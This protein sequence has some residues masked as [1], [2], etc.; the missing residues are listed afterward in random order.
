MSE[1]AA[2]VQLARS[3]GRRSYRRRVPL[4]Y[5]K[6]YKRYN[7]YRGYRSAFRKA[8]A[9]EFPKGS[10]A[11]ISFY[12]QDEN[13]ANPRQKAARK[14]S[15]YRGPGAYFSE[16]PFMA[17]ALRGAGQWLG[18]R[19]MPGAGGT[20][21]REMAGRASKWLGFGAYHT[22][23]SG[24]DLVVDMPGGGSAQQI[25]SVADET[26]DLVI[27]NTEFIGNVVVT[28]STA[29]S[30]P[31]SVQT[32]ALNPGITA[33]F[34]FLSQIAQN[35][36]LYD[37]QQLLFQ[38]KPLSGESGAASNNLGS[39]IM[40]THYDPD[41]A[42]FI[43]KIQMENY[44]YS[45]STKPSC[46]AV[47]GV[48]CKPGSSSTN[49]LYVRA[50]AVSR[51]KIFTDVGTFQLAT[52]G[53]PFASA[54]SQVV[55]ELHVTYTVTLS[56]PQL[57]NSLLG[58]GIMQD[59]FSYTVAQNSAV[60]SSIVASA[61][62]LI[63]GVVSG[64]NSTQLYTFPTSIVAGTYLFSLVMESNAAA[65]A[66]NVVFPATAVGCTILV[67]QSTPDVNRPE[68]DKIAS[69]VIVRVNGSGASVGW[70]LNGNA[71]A[72][73]YTCRLMC[74]QVNSNATY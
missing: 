32:F 61:Q 64:S 4:K 73:A 57:F 54:G 42:T 11:S 47:H 24:N 29:G 36:E 13:T 27:R 52:E 17:S 70:Q 63:G 31:F 46:G 12:G 30:S 19:V 28:S 23:V 38:Y 34:P 72:Q 45:N 6:A 43:N 68:N 37:W 67:N 59:V 74:V 69:M 18:D 33:T 1:L 40:A 60:P 55:G 56:R 48:E 3:M 14:L 58:L 20:F 2:G 44:A 25:V 65:G 71:A 21:G 22:G 62:N 8:F 50:G 16:S 10:E 15:G 51:D 26:G 39:I 35:Y 49:M 53:I 41:G 66:N 7:R 5:M 9:A